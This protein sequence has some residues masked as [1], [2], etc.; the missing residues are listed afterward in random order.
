MPAMSVS[1]GKVKSTT[2]LYFNWMG[3]SAA[4][5]Y[6]TKMSAQN[7]AVNRNAFVIATLHEKAGEPALV[8]PS[9]APASG[10]R[11]AG[12]RS[13]LAVANKI[14]PPEPRL[15][16]PNLLCMGLFLEN[17]GGVFFRRPIPSR[18]SEPAR[19]FFSPTMT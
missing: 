17:A 3:S 2:R 18:R 12:I 11:T 5:E 16:R 19:Y 1:I 13:Q 15:P 10:A 7:D 9:G 4:A 6:A 14:L 8:L